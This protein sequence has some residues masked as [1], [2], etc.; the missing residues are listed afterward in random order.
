MRV[1]ARLL[2]VV[3]AATC[4]EE[5][6]SQMLGTPYQ[7]QLPVPPGCEDR[8]T[9][10]GGPN[11]FFCDFS[12]TAVAILD[13]Q[14]DSCG[15]VRISCFV[16]GAGVSCYLFPNSS[17]ASRWSAANLL[18]PAQAGAESLGGCA[19]DTLCSFPYSPSRS[20]RAVYLYTRRRERPAFGNVT[21]TAGK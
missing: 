12:D 10:L 11:G 21:V 6:L 7:L 20:S 5:G 16:P 2:L 19:N 18:S 15:S 4:L 9:E 3:L 17:E 14:W 13:A 1:A 8:R